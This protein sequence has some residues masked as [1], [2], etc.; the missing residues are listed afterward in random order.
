MTMFKTDDIISTLQHLGMIQ[1]MKGQHVICAAPHVID[2]HLRKC[3]SAGLEVDPTKIVWCPV[4]GGWRSRGRV[5]STPSRG[6]PGLQKRRGTAEHTAAL[7]AKSSRLLLSRH[8]SPCRRPAVRRTCRVRRGPLTWRHAA[9]ALAPRLARAAPL[10]PSFVHPT[11]T[12]RR[13]LPPAALPLAPALRPCHLRH[14][15]L[16][17]HQRPPLQGSLPKHVLLQSVELCRGSGCWGQLL[18]NEFGR[19]GIDRNRG[20]GG[21]DTAALAG[22]G[23]ACS[24]LAAPAQRARCLARG[25]AGDMGR[26]ATARVCVWGGTL[27]L[28]GRPRSWRSACWCR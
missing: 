5:G 18:C 2:Q 19:G 16:P 26:A 8:A 12:L 24:A 25:T 14:H 13:P 27:L 15:W 17:L 3:G 4:G 6:R 11:C 1:Y 20:R 7:A 28:R 23:T 21:R 22:L 10:K 9:P